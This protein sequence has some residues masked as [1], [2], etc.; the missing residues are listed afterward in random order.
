LSNLGD[1]ISTVDETIPPAVFNAKTIWNTDGDSILSHNID[2]DVGAIVCNEDGSGYLADHMYIR[3]AEKS[4]WVDVFKNH[5]HT[6]DTDGG[7]YQEMRA[8]NAKD[9]LELNY[10]NL[11]K[12]QFVNV[13]TGSAA[14][15]DEVEVPP[16]GDSAYVELYSPIDTDYCNM[17]SGGLRLHFGKPFL[18]Q[19][20]YKVFENT[21]ILFRI[22]AGL[23]SIEN[24]GNQA[25]IGW[26]GCGSEENLTVVSADGDDRSPDYLSNMLQPNPIGLRI[27]YYVNRIVGTDGL[28]ALTNKTDNLPPPSTATTGYNT[29]AIG[30][31]AGAT[32]AGQPRAMRVFSGY[33][34]GYIY[35]S[36]T[37]VGAWV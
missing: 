16:T 4:A 26:E 8:A 35:D 24:S 28:G 32:T 20:K 30:L 33:L 3:N 23:S 2:Q 12:G 10:Q 36:E 22:G 7:T 31:K 34:L 19:A 6:S 17:Y 15:T 14:T 37:G 1:L 5:L 9:I 27:E 21:N 11:R 29:F 18:M 13:V 25:Q